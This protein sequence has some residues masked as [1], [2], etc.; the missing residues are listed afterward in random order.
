MPIPPQTEMFRI[1]LEHY[2]DGKEYTRRQIRDKVDATLGLTREE[3]CFRTSS[4]A[5]VYESRTSW[6]VT[7]LHK[8]GYLNRVRRGT[9]AITETGKAAFAKSP[10]FADFYQQMYRDESWSIQQSIVLDNSE[11]IRDVSPEE[12]ISMGE[13]SLREQL[14]NDLMDAIMEIP[15]REGDTFFEKIVTD[16]L[17]HIGYGEG[18][19]TS[20]NNDFGIDGIIT[21]DVLG[22]DPI[23]IQAKRYSK[24]NVVGRP[25]VQAFAG[26][27][28]S[29]S[30]G[31]FITTSAFNDNAIQYAKSY[32]HADL[33]LI[34]G[35]KLTNLMIEYD[36]G[37]D[38][39]K[40]I[41]LKRLNSDYFN[42]DV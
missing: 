34:D 41:K 3:K 15:G 5:P 37:V 13:K 7:H 6:A 32:P 33:V 42:R 19:V 22:F 39:E 4:G 26:A 28:G 17:V 11:G 27:L 12:M 31:V 29:I 30:R 18:R 25:D 9:Y 8:A 10:T 16:L 38:T 36:L 40:V 24:D 20:A 2:A 1:V 35:V 21:T 23:Y 14:A